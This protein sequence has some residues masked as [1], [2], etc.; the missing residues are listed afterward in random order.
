MEFASM[1]GGWIS[2]SYVVSSVLFDLLY[3]LELFSPSFGYLAVVGMLFF[4]FPIFLDAE[5]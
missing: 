5:L 3:G 1:S 2:A 4:G